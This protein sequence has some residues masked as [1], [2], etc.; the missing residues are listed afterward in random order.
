MSKVNTT[1][2]SVIKFNRSIIYNIFFLCITVSLLSLAIYNTTQSLYNL[3]KE[4]IG[5][6]RVEEL[7][8]QGLKNELDKIPNI[9][10]INYIGDRPGLH[11]KDIPD[12]CM[13][14]YFLSQFIL[15]PTILE[16][17]NN[18]LPW[19]MTNLRNPKFDQEDMKHW[20]VIKNFNQGIILLKNQSQ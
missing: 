5:A 10:N 12:L 15:A 17:G 11:V 19:A 20:K 6:S 3:P 1:Q 9:K 8:L 16:L 7:R 13:E 14:E 4:G 2:A 18:N